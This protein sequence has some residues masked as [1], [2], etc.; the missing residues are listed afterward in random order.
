[1]TEL[2]LN[3]QAEGYSPIQKPSGVH[4]P[5]LADFPPLTERVYQ[6]AVNLKGLLSEYP[7]KR[8]TVQKDN[9]CD[10]ACPGCYVG[11]WIE[12]DG[13]V[14][15]SNPRRRTDEDTILAQTDS[16]PALEEFF[17]LGAEP[18]LRPANTASLLAAAANRG[19][20]IMS[21]TNGQG[22]GARNE[23]AFGKAIAEQGMHKLNVSIDSLDPDVNDFLR[24]KSG[25][26]ERTIETIKQ[27]IETG[28]PIKAQMT[29][30]G[31]N[32]ATILD[33]VEKLYEMGVRGF[34]FHSGSVEATA[35]FRERGLEVIDPLSWRALAAKL[36][37]FAHNHQ[38]ELTHFN[39]PLLYLDEDELATVFQD[40]TIMEAYMG[41]VD[42][43]ETG[44]TRPLPFKL[45]PAFG[46]PENP[47]PPQVYVYANDGDGEISVCQV[48]TGATG[49]KFATWDD[50]QGEFQVIK[51]SRN[52]LKVMEQSPHLCPSTPSVTGGADSDRVVTQAG[53]LY[54]G[55]RYLSNNQLPNIDWTRYSGYY[56]QALS[57]YEGE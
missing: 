34:A 47:G 17:Y 35:D 31:A 57:H 14:R 10:L 12:A 3:D 39:V 7:V 40:E 55:C 51:G 26:M 46:S 33:S 37:E 13:A 48:H 54:Y 45:C 32:Y 49:A 6:R 1:M 43:V 11:Q 23:T 24:G 53:N 52:Q 27:G 4:E 42:A 21:V 25:A 8:V 29:V 9:E 5:T 15:L 28:W 20:R 30:W 50:K 16:L 2:R 44:S 22:A 56:E 18:S 36:M 38:G 19:L 41:H